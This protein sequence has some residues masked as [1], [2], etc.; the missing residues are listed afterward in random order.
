MEG[1]EVEVEGGMSADNWE[2]VSRDCT[3][4]HY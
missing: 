2:P 4:C 1:P 3:V